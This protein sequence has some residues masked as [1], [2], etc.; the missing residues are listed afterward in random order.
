MEKMTPE[1]EESCA[2]SRALAEVLIYTCK[3]HMLAGIGRSEER[4]LIARAQQETMAAITALNV[5]ILHLFFSQ[6]SLQ[7]ATDH[8]VKAFRYA[9]YMYDQQEENKDV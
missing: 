6:D 1:Q 4:E 7:L 5:E 9:M 8:F 2:Q 3:Q